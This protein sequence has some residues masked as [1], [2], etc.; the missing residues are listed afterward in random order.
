M[1]YEKMERAF[2]CLCGR[3]RMLAEWQEHDTWP[4]S[5]R[6]IRW[7]FECPDCA[8]GYEFVDILGQHIVGKGDALEY[9]TMRA[10][11][12]QAYQRVLDIAVPK[13]EE[14]WV[15]YV[16][17]LPTKAAK[18]RALAGCSYGTFLKRADDRRWLERQARSRF[19]YKAK[20]CLR[21]M[22]IDDVE[23]NELNE[24]AEAARAAA[25][26][27]WRGINKQEVPLD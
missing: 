9:L 21:E 10:A 23:V 5:S 26:S 11:Y 4:S 12:D 22:G 24:A 15:E 27:F 13:Y 8:M 1:G 6:C 14:K 25:D 3:G 17:S 20:D 19:R 2:P 16:F 18:H 7:H